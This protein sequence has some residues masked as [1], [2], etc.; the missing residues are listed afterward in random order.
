MKAPQVYRIEHALFSTCNFWQAPERYSLE[1]VL[2]IPNVLFP[3]AAWHDVG[4][5]WYVGTMEDQALWRTIGIKKKA[6]RPFP[7]SPWFLQREHSKDVSCWCKSQSWLYNTEPKVEIICR[8]FCMRLLK[9]NKETSWHPRPPSVCWSILYLVLYCFFVMSTSTK[10]S[11]VLVEVLV[12]G[13]HW[14]MA[15]RM[16]GMSEWHCR[17]L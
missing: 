15:R 7:S 6:D 13:Y 9:N 8:N 14:W 11:S 1:S 4:G 5:W 3:F 17:I 2:L 12:V 16:L 10:P